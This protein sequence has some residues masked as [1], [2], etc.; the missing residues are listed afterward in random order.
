MDKIC[1]IGHPS[2]LG[3]A[4]TELDHQIRVWQAMGLKVYILHTGTIDE[5]LKNM[6]MEERGCTY[7]PVRK[8][9]ACKDM[10]VIGYCNDQFLKNLRIIKEHAKAV[11]WVNC[12]TWLFGPE[13]DAHKAG[14]IDLFLYQTHHAQA[15]VNNDLERTNPKYNWMVSKPYFHAEDFPFTGKRP[16][17]KF[18]FGRVSRDDPTKFNHRQMWIYD[19]MVAPVLKEGKILGWGP[20]A[21]IQAKL[22]AP[23]PWIQTFPAGGC[24]AQDVYASSD[25]IIQAC[26]T[27][28]N[29]PRVAFEAMS[30]GCLLI[31]D[32]R[33][34]WIEQVEHGKTGFLCENDRDFVYYSSRAAYET[35]ERRKMTENARDWLTTNWGMES[36]KKEW[37]A[38]FNKVLAK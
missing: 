22:G 29:L 23:P 33:G 3:G 13:K 27:Y 20:N 18:R 19:T 37:A 26:D 8:W 4:D 35:E 24:R 21:G 15:R 36:S 30:S 5:N 10:V 38:V 2:R 14:L 11:I 25:C 6:R 34:G 16:D 9:E 31:V 1:V 32:K 7:L 28:E 17:D 12:M